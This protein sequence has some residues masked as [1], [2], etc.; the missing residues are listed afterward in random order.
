[1]NQIK[2]FEHEMF[3]EL[4]VIVVDD[5]EWFG[6]TE[7]AKALS[8]GNPYD[9]LKN[10]VEEDDLAVH[11]VIDRLGRKQHKKFISESGLYSLIIGAAKQGNNQQI[12]QR[13]KVFKKW[14]TSDVL[15]TIRKTGGYVQENRA[16]DFVNSWLPQLD[17]NSK[18]AV[19][20]TLEQNR[21]LVTENKKL[22]TTI[23]SQKPKVLFAE[24]LEISENSILVKD[25]ATLLKQNGVDTGQNRLFKWMREEG[26]LL[27]RSS[28]YN[29][30]SQKS[31]EQGLFEFGTRV[32]TH[33]DGSTS[34]RY[35][36]YVTGKGQ[37]YF[38]NKFIDRRG[39]I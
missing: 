10:H 17:D 6:A 26:Y 13:A 3:G 15:P 12:K 22:V 11:E 16:I 23:E 9:A 33:N 2:S 20:S 14:V 19:A 36:P 32:I 30:P 34:N 29:K 25:L 37:I 31:M 38:M 5:V 27:K 28:Y 7:G 1:M 35:T 8:F 4:P 21:Y 18:Q 39:V 24:A